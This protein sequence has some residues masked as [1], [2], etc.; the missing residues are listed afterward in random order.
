M[1][2]YATDETPELMPLTIMLSHKL[3]MK[4]SELRRNGELPWL[5][6]VRNFLS[7]ALGH[8]DTGNLRVQDDRRCTRAATCAYYC[9]KYAA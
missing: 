3:N 8:Q 7:Y 2:G 1:F 4:M 6:P 5:R 9:Y